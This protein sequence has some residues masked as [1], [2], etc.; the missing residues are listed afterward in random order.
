MV[1]WDRF[2]YRN[3]GSEI[4][5]TTYDSRGKI[6]LL[7]LFNQYGLFRNEAWERYFF[8]EEDYDYIDPED[9]ERYVVQ[10]N[11]NNLDTADGRQQ[12]ESQINTLIQ[13]FPG[14]VVPEGETF[15]FENYYM[16]WALYYRRDTSRFDPVKLDAAYEEIKGAI[17]RSSDITKN[18]MIGG[19]ERS[20]GHN[21]VGTEMPHRLR[22]MEKRKAMQN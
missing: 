5:P 13:D 21:T 12:F 20:V 17:G 2:M 16:R 1:E 7:E 9:Y 6:N 14:L 3:Y 19:E 15:D 4:T 18:I 10:P 8:N 11:G 22:G